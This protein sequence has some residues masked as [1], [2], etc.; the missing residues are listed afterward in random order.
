MQ[1]VSSLQ[2]QTHITPCKVSACPTILQ[3]N[4]VTFH[5]SAIARCHV[6]ATTILWEPTEDQCDL[7]IAIIRDTLPHSVH[8]IFCLHLVSSS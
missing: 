4:V 7:D 5:D 6:L 2:V 1:W 3:Y 8:I